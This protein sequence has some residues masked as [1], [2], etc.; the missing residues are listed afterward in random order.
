MHR[1]C[2]HAPMSPAVCAP[3]HDTPT[4]ACASAGHAKELP[5]QTSARS[6]SPVPVLQIAPDSLAAHVA[7]SQHPSSPAIAAHTAVESNKH[8]LP[9]QHGSFPAQSPPGQSHCSSPSTTPLPHTD[10]RPEVKHPNWFASTAALND[11]TLQSE[12]PSVSTP[13]SNSAAMTCPDSGQ[14]P[15]PSSPFPLA[16]GPI[17]SCANP[18]WW[19]ISCATVTASKARE[20]LCTCDRATDNSGMQQSF[21]PSAGP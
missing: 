2:Q 7:G 5:S 12:K 4:G 10:S 3:P 17:P 18:S 13:Y 15:V 9:S 20:V 1:P 8:V 6:H 19:P 11:R 14:S 21:S 16:S